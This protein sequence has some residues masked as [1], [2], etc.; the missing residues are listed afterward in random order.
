[1]KNSLLLSF[2]FLFCF[3][4][5][6]QPKKEYQVYCIGFYNLENLFDTINDPTN[7]ESFTPQGEYHYDSKIYYDKLQKLSTVISKIGVNESKDGL[8]FWGTAEIE[9]Q[10][11]LEDLCKQPLLAARNYKVIEHESP[12]YR[13]I[14]CAFVYNP[15]YFTPI[16]SQTLPMRYKQPN[17]TT[18]STTR[19]ILWVE[20][21][22]NGETFHVFVNHWPSRRGGEEATA[23]L[24]DMAAGICKA[25][26]DSIYKANPSA[27]VIVMGDLNDDPV[28]NSCKKVLNAK[29]NPSDVKPGGLF[30][31]FYEHYKKGLGTMAFRDAWGLF[32]QIIVSHNFI[33]KNQNGLFFYK[34]NVFHEDFMV[35]KSGPFKG[36]P[37]R[38]FSGAEYNGGYSDHYPTYITILKSK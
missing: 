19:D 15:K 14:D 11:C 8:A 22:M 10:H 37:S 3:Q 2:I 32:D 13:G 24:R 31:P 1:M 6:A 35:Q 5:N 23:P 30:N 12:D 29:G 26:S 27:K 4:M 36:Y 17:D 9:H 34:A 20:G 18:P 28:S 25:K 7:D 38:T 21:L 33:D 16:N